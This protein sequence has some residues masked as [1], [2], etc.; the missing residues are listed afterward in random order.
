[1]PKKISFTK[2]MIIKTSFQLLKKQGLSAITARN[3]AKK[4]GCSPAPIYSSFESMDDLKKE[5]MN[6][7]KDEFLKCAK[8]HYTHSMLLNIGMGIITFA[9]DE[10][11]LFSFVFFD[12]EEYKDLMYEFSDLIFK[13]FD[14]DDRLKKLSKKTR[15]WLLYK[16]WIY[17]HGY[18]TLIRTGYLSETDNK[19]IVRHLLEVADLFV[20]KAMNLEE[21]KNSFN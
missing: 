14:N 16:G 13:E 8:K 4:L 7:A 1:M 11:Q 2:E 17:A 18:A 12:K 21:N 10:N 3:I 19:S 6:I 20:T 15:K 5:L 9:R